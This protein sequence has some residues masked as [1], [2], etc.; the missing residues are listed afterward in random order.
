MLALL[1]RG[2]GR[3][4]RVVPRATRSCLSSDSINNH[5]HVW[6]IARDLWHHGRLPWRM[7]VLAHGEAYAYPYGFVNWTTAALVWPL[8]GNWAVT[9]WTALGAVGCIVAT[10]IAFPELRRG[11][12]AAA[13]L[14]NP[15]ILEALLFGQQS[16]AWGAMLLLFGIA[17]LAA[18]ASGVGRGPR[19]PRAGEPRRDRPAD[20]R[21]ARRCYYLPFAPDRRALLRWYALSC[22]IALPAVVARVRVARPPPTRAPSGRSSSNFFITLGP[23]IIIVGLPDRSACGSAAH[24]SRALAPV[25]VVLALI[26]PSRLRDPAE[27]RP[28]V[29]ARS[30]HNGADTA[31]LDAYLRSP[32]FVPGATYRVL[33][34]GDGKLGLYHVLRAGGRLDSEMFPES[35]AI[36]ELPRR[37]RLRVA[38]VRPARRPDHPLRHLR[39]GAAHERAGDDRRA[40]AR[41]RRRRAPATGRERHRLAGR[42]GRPGALCPRCVRTVRRVGARPGRVALPPWRPSNGGSTSAIPT[43]RRCGPCCRPASTRPRWTGSCAPARRR[44]PA[45]PR[46]HGDYVFGVLVL[47]GDRDNGEV[48]FQE[49]DVIANLDVLV[50]VRKTPRRSHRVRVRRRPRTPRCATT[51]RP[52]CACTS[53]STRSPSGSSRWSTASTTASTSSRTTSSDWPSTEIREQHLEHPP[54][55]P[56]TSGACSRRRATRRAPCSTTASSSTATSR[57][58]PRHRAALRRRV[59]QVAAR[60]RR[61]RP[62]ARPARGRARLPPGAGRERPE[63]SDEAA[64][65]RR[66]GAARSR[67]SS[68]ACTAR[69]SGTSPSS[70]GRTATCARGV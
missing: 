50:T 34:G 68:S 14:A 3:R 37:R 27:R 55:H 21:A 63:R 54:R 39:H 13:V 1:A 24:G 40:R 26:A 25:G 44:A 43:S 66:V 17:A 2:L 9:L 12:W 67:R 47:P 58:S 18:R 15:A 30:S 29:A 60:D 8:F 23:R 52:A 53:S 46:G 69:T 64:D 33:R 28:A 20:R 56:R 5:V 59:R 70:A 32:D 61:P 36:R 22:V 19:R 6:Y 35:M 10:F 42:R 57:C 4:P 38:A 48:V 31:T 49:V 7:P 45:P 51:R 16:F 41:S 62:R 11:W 65:R